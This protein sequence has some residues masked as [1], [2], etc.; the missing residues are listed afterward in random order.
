MAVNTNKILV[1]SS[2]FRFVFVNPISQDNEKLPSFLSTNKGT[3]YTVLTIKPP[4]LPISKY[5]EFF[6]NKSEPL[7]SNYVN[8]LLLPL[9][10]MTSPS[11]VVWEKFPLSPS[12]RFPHLRFEVFICSP[13]RL[14][15]LILCYWY[16]NLGDSYSC[17]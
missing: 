2:L 5:L 9:G 4:I 15:T 11:S 3:Q 13:L 12:V 10:S 6:I 8:Y 14:T 17:I 1:L 7:Q 16:F